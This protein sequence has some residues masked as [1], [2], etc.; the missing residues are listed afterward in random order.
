LKPDPTGWIVRGAEKT[1]VIG[2][3]Q[4]DLSFGL[5]AAG[6]YGEG[7]ADLAHLWRAEGA[8]VA[9]E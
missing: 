2:Q 9:V 1:N 3:T 8:D 5:G 4:A 7:A 6:G